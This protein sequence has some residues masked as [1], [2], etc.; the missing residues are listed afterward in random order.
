MWDACGEAAGNDK[1]IRYQGHERR[2]RVCEDADGGNPT[3]QTP[4]NDLYLR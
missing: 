3:E 4:A 1:R 2:S